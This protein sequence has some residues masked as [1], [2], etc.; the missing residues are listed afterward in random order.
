VLIAAVVLLFTGRYH[1]G[2]FDFIMGVNRWAYRVAAY[3]LLLRDEYPP[4][5][6]DQGPTD[7]P[8]DLTADPTPPITATPGPDPRATG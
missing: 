8:A 2:I 6:L 3:V 4:F 7:P 1:R 5:R